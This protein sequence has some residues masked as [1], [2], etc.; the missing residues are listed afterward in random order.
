MLR[1]LEEKLAVIV[2][3]NNEL[4]KFHRARAAAVLPAPDSYP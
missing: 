3:A 4:E 1:A 2:N